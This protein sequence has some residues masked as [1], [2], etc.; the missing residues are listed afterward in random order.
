MARVPLWRHFPCELDLS[1]CN[2]G[3]ERFCRHLTMLIAIRQSV[4]NGHS[5]IM[6]VP[7]VIVIVPDTQRTRTSS[8]RV[9]AC[10]CLPSQVHVVSSFTGKP[11][12]FLLL[13]CII[14]DESCS[15][16]KQLNPR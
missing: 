6:S 10:V 4:G 8:V 15:P 7:P 11:C 12:P 2:E 5:R 14:F 16:R 1:E 3:P 9:C 13:Y